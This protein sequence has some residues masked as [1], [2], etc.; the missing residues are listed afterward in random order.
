MKYN[1]TCSNCKHWDLYCT[2]GKKEYY[3]CRTH[4]L[5]K[6]GLKEAL[7]SKILI[8]ELKELI[9]KNS[10]KNIRKN[11]Q[12]RKELIHKLDKNRWEFI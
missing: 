4:N 8:K 2:L 11:A 6:F 1:K 12:A 5:N 9:E 10:R 7:I 3:W